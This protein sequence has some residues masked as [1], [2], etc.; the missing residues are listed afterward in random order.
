[1]L[2][3]DAIWD[4]YRSFATLRNDQRWSHTSENDLARSQLENT[5]R[6]LHTVLINALYLQHSESQEDVTFDS[7]NTGSIPAP[8]RSAAHTK[9]LKRLLRVPIPEATLSS[10]FSWGGLMEGLGK[11]SLNLEAHG[12]L[13]P[14]HSHLNHACRPNV[15]IRHISPDGSTNSILHSPNPS[16]ITV[17]AA[18]LIPAGVELVVS[19]VD[20]SL[21]LRSRRRELRAWDFG[22]CQCGRCLEEEN[23]NSNTEHPEI[24]G[25]RTKI[26]GGDERD[27]GQ[28]EDELRGF[29]SV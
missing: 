9:Q 2:S 27:V 17:I 28:L 15:S 7:T 19:Y 18:S 12:G 20:P 26:G 21:D 14:L 11:M 25:N 8:S 3:K 4:T 13:F 1:P 16:R 10:L 6:R 24:S 23:S 5:F 29:L 22:I